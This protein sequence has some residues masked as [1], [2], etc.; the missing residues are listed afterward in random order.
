MKLASFAFHS[1]P[2]LTAE[3]TSRYVRSY[4]VVLLTSL[5]LPRHSL[6]LNVHRREHVIGH[7]WYFHDLQTENNIDRWIFTA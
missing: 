7:S 6:P 1:V 4:F 5:P 3:N 2:P